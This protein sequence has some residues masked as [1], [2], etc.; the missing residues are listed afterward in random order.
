MAAQG[1]MAVVAEAVPLTAEMEETADSVAEVG[2]DGPVSWAAHMAA[3][4]DSEV[5]GDEP[6][7]AAY[8]LL[9]SWKWGNV[10][11][12]TRTPSVAVAGGLGGVNF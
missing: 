6:Q 11:E 9:P 8:W 3:M 5:A 1:T 12:A 4:E 2:P 7:T 10:R